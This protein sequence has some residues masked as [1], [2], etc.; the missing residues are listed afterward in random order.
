MRNLLN[1]LIKYN[2]WFL[3]IFLELISFG[4]LFRFNNYQQSAYFTSANVIAGNLYEISGGISSYFHLKSVNDDLLDRNML[5]EKQIANLENTLYQLKYDTTQI[6]SLKS[7]SS[8]Q[9][10]LHKANVINNSLNHVDNYITLDQGSTAGIKPDM[11]VVDQ[12]GVVGIVY[13]TSPSYSLVISILNSKSSLSCKILGSDYFG[14]LKWEDGDSR[15]A[16]LRDLPRHAEFKLGDTVVTSGYSSVFPEGIVVG[17]VDDIYDSNDGLSY[18]LKVLLAA[19]FGK[20]NNVRI[21]DRINQQE[22]IEL[23][24]NKIR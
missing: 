11:G 10:S 13:K 12:N 7:L 22:K 9:Y 20:L 15:Y 14:S 19:D 23:E 6:A 17:S 8:N 18:T 16:Y 24:R 5:L 3:F 4:L 21:I 2:Y 1:F